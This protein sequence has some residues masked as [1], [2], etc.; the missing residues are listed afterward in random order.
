MS[1]HSN[2]L[3]EEVIS[4]IA[5]RGYAVVPGAVAASDVEAALDLVTG[6][7]QKR[8]T[9]PHPG[10][11]LIKSDEPFI[12]NLQNE[13]IFPLSLFIDN[14]LIETVLKHFLND[15]WYRQIPQD[16]PNYIMRT[17]LARSNVRPLALHIDS[18]VPAPGEFTSIMQVAIPLEDQSPENGCTMVV[19]GSHRSGRWAR[20][21]DLA[22]AVPVSSKAG[23]L[24]FWDSRIWHST[25]ENPSGRSRWSMIYTCTRWWIK[26]GFDIT[27]TLPQEVYDKLTPSQKAVLGFCSIPPRDESERIDMK[28][29]LDDLESHVRFYGRK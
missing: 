20:Q 6:L 2:S 24:V 1:T 25:S 29:G 11:Y 15:P 7:W 19:P 28:R 10:S 27:G 12:W 22:D 21:E 17:L 5:E 26:Q 14:A 23:D 18:F 9:E 16:Q 4:R 3:A 8:S 13:G